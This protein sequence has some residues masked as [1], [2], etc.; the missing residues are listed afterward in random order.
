MGQWRESLAAADAALAT[1]VEKL[2]PTEGDGEPR[3]SWFVLVESNTTGSGRLFCARAREFGLTPV[4][5]ARDPQRYP[6]L[7]TD[8]IDTRVV[9]TTDPAAVRAAVAALPGTDRRDHQQL[10][11]LHR[12]R[13]RT[14][15][16]ARPAPPGPGGDAGVPRQVPPAAVTAGG[17]GADAASQAART[18]ADAVA[19]AD[20]IG[21]PVVVKPIAGSGS[22][23]TRRC[24]HPDEVAQAAATV[25]TAD[26]A[27]LGLPPQEAVLVEEYLT[28]TEYS[29]ETFDDEVVGITRKY[30]GPEPYFIEVGHDF[31]APLSP[32]DRQAVADT[33]VAALRA[34]GLGWGPAHV[35][36]RL[37]ADRAAHCGGQSPPRRR[38]DPPGGTKATGVDLI[39]QTVARAAGRPEKPAPSGSR[40]PRSASLW[41]RTPAGWWRSR[42]GGGPGGARGGARGDHPPAG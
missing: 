30:L 26:P 12:Y 33:A 17:R 37:D 15:P 5:L 34:L 22:V 39:R 36:L 1:A 32:G 40:P 23:A 2:R 28:G 21:Y 4:V 20:R 16:G 24:G 29:V 35:E 10:R 42:G 41:R 7:A 27:A 19:A 14:G 11:V 3:M 31:P 6:Y 8:R 38:H 9:D 25:L 18:V 13:R